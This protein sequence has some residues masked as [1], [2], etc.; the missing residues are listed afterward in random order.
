MKGRRLRRNSSFSLLRWLGIGLII[1]AS[2]LLVVQLVKYSR[3]RARFP[4]GMLIA[5]I[6]VGE[7]DYTEASE[8][9]L[10]AYLSPIEVQYQDAVIQVR[11]ASL[12]FD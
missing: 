9:L 11:P 2:F 7:L 6:P 5:D 3:I 1:L 4:T 12:G 10:T 8:R